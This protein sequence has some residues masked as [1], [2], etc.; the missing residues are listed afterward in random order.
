MSRLCP[1]ECYEPLTYK[2]NGNRLV[3]CATHMTPGVHAKSQLLCVYCDN[4]AVAIIRRAKSDVSCCED[5]IPGSTIPSRPPEYYTFPGI[6][7]IRELKTTYCTNSKCN[8]SPNFGMHANYFDKCTEHSQNCLWK[9]K[10][11]CITPGC[12][13][14]R[15]RN[16]EKCKECEKQSEIFI[17]L[18]E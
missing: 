2:L 10:Y 17:D 18:N 15:L 6:N 5:H 11:I 1:G 4:Y 13:K 8:R 9:S 3:I 14:P 12:V 16:N 7:R